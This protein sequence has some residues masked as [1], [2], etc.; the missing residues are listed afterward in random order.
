MKA[1]MWFTTVLLSLLLVV[2][3]YAR[4]FTLEE[5]I[6]FDRTASLYDRKFTG[7]VAAALLSVNPRE[8]KLFCDGLSSRGIL[9]R[10]KYVR[11]E[12]RVVLYCL[13]KGIYDLWGYGGRETLLSRARKS[14]CDA[15]YHAHVY[16][17]KT[18]RYV[19][20]DF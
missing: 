5:K 2:S 15:S 7:M 8:A 3:V 6:E 12:A 9:T 11:D 17:L 1:K 20:S 13:D 16:K 4:G 18:G 10:Y 19:W 14:V